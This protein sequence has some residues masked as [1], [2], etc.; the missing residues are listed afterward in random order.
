MATISG[1]GRV[2]IAETEARPLRPPAK[3]QARRSPSP[4]WMEAILTDWRRRWPAA[5]ARP[6]PLAVGISRH[7]KEALRAE[8]EAVDREAI[9][10]TLHRWTMQGAY[11][12]AVARGEMRRNLDGS[13]A[14]VP[15]DAARQQAQTL[16][17]E[18]AARR[19][20]RER[21]KQTSPD[22]EGPGS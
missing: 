20:E 8:G 18:R 7:I 21:A 1:V 10:G 9:G 3:G 12:R 13:A 22:G 5:F 17:D 6:V 16:L 14:G 11:L 15:D 4:P 19:A 2:T